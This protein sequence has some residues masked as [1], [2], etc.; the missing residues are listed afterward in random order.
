MD[1]LVDILILWTHWI[2][3]PTA[4]A[5]HGF[6]WEITLIL[7]VMSYF[8]IAA[9]KTLSAFAFQQFDYV[10]SRCYSLW[11]C[12][13]WSSLSFLDVWIS[14]FV[15]ILTNLGYFSHYFFMYSFYSSCCIPSWDSHCVCSYIWIHH[16]SLRLCSLF[17]FFPFSF[18]S[19]S[20]QK[21]SSCL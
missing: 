11:G 21:D 19:S 9:F 18:C 1:L 14:V 16:R 15:F 20:E 6:W 10:L 2:H 8:S 7:Q 12:L 3:H 13:T 17:F 4:S 5:V